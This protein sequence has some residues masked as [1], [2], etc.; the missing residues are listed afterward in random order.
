MLIGYGPRNITM[1]GLPSGEPLRHS[2]LAVFTPTG[3]LPAASLTVPGY[4][5]EHVA[6][7]AGRLGIDR[8]ICTEAVPP[9]RARSRIHS[10]ASA[11]AGTAEIRV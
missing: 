6:A 7:L 5:A 2:F 11:L 9:D 3:S 8:E 4:A 1:V 10:A